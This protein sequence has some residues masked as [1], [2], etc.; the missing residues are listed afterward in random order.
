MTE[1]IDVNDA[2]RWLGSR[3][4]MAFAWYGLFLLELAAAIF[5]VVKA[6]IMYDTQISEDINVKDVVEMLRN[7]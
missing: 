4:P 6:Y 7:E 3:K 2:I 1:N 5:I